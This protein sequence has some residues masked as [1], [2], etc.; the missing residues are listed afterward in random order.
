MTYDSPA[1]LRQALEARL[2]RQAIE[3][4]VDLERL[5]RRAVFERILVR[6]EQV[7]PGRW[8]LK[9]G[10]ALEVRLRDRARTT[11]D[12]DLVV[13]E[14]GYGGDAVR[15]L[16][17]EALAVDVEA[18]GFGFEVGRPDPLQPDEAGRSGWRFPV[19]ASMGGRLFAQVRVDV[20]P[21]ADEVTGT[22]LVTLPGVFSFAGKTP[23]QV[24]VVDRRQHFAEKLHA[25]TRIYSS[26]RPSS[27]VKDLPDL[28][29]L[30]EDGLEP[31]CDLRAVVSDLFEVRRTH[32]M[33]VEIPDPP[34]DWE[35][36]YL[37]LVEELDLPA[38]TLDEAMATLRRFWDEVLAADGKE[39]TSGEA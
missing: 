9:G 13:R 33:P 7:S 29:L 24:E 11:K 10:M 17:I 5:R 28:L 34:A 14:A 23:V 35:V 6:L 12:L 30:I 26:D 3:E 1:A 25:L 2:H 36:R 8:V 18:D 32:P 31:S 38:R 37:S 27:R 22:E 19:R 39:S 15:D 16:L 20:V 4:R 21:R